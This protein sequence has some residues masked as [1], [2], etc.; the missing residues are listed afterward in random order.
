MRFRRLSA[1][2]LDGTEF[3]VNTN[4]PDPKTAA[5]FWDER[6][7]TETPSKYWTEY[8]AVRRYVNECMT[9]VWWAYPT[10]GFKAGW[11]YQPLR[12]GLSI[13]CG[14]GN[15]EKDL[16]WLR[17]CEEADAFDISAESIRIAKERA[18]A[19][20]IDHVHFEVA[21]CERLDYPPNRYDVVFFH[22]S[23][24]HISKPAQLL[25]RI[26]PALRENALLYLDDYVGPSRDQWIPKH[27]ARAQ[28]VYA[29]LP[30]EWRRSPEVFIPYDS[31]DPSEM[32]NSSQIVPAIHDRFDILWERPYWGNLLYPLLCAVND[33]EA[34]KP[35]NEAAL[36]SLISKEKELVASGEF[37]AP[38]FTWIVGRKHGTRAG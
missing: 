7:L 19:E 22:G 27:L 14:T 6:A 28:E 36:T 29:N 4:P 21:D 38:L 12:R 35:E 18:A 34:S 13:G 11:A 8:P 23:L 1:E 2:P 15:L 20:D 3:N 37:A 33:R 5:A 25:D 9:D 26:L 17:I 31:T 10:H 32:I 24:H 30:V 16:R